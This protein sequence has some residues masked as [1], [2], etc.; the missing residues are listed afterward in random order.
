MALRRGWRPVERTIE[1]GLLLDPAVE[2]AEARGFVVRERHPGHVLLHRDGTQAAVR[3]EGFPLDLALAEA[4][5]GVFLQVRYDTFALFDT[6]DLER[7]ADDLVR[8]LRGDD[9]PAS[10]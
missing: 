9:G 2:R 8:A 4:E 5:D 7:V 1:D 10:A 6:G 3:G